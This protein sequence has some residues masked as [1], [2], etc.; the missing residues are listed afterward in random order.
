MAGE[1]VTVFYRNEQR[2][3][4]R[5]EDAASVAA[6]AAG[7]VPGTARW[8]GKVLQP[9]ARSSVDCE[10]AAQAVLSFA[11]NRAAAIAG[12]YAAVNLQ[13]GTDVWPGDVLALTQNGVDDERGGAEGARWSGSRRCRRW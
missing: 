12:S 11:T 1:L 5:L 2:A 10:S 7:G 13:Q 3:L 9:V 8:L 6:E 4:A